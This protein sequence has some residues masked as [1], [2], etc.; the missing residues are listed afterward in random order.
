MKE[1]NIL[2]LTILLFITSCGMK[3]K[4]DLTE[5]YDKNKSE[6]IKL[7]N[8]F[9]EIVPKGF[10]VSIRYESSDEI[11][12]FVYEPIEN[13]EKSEL[14]FQ[15]WNL[16]L[17]NYEPKAQTEYEKKY[18]GK[19]NSLEILKQKLNWNDETFAE[20]Y[21][22][23]ENVNC[24][25][26]SNG[27]STEIEYGFKGT[28]VFSY[29]IFDKNLSKEL[30]EKYSDDCSQMFYKDNIVLKYGSGA[31]GSFCIPEFKRTK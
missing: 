14:L 8:Y 3:S 31:I 19:T 6:I 16:N 12:L 2:I 22:K 9:N 25:G 24:I 28:G 26:I 21:N 13:S 29:E 11:N 30:Q 10:I 4:Q 17:D 5:N 18:N 7:K 23:L 1:Q 15:Q 27:N 20:L